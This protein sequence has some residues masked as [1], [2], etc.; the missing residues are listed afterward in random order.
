MGVIIRNT[1]P[2]LDQLQLTDRELMREVG[3]LARERIIRRTAAGK[4]RDGMSFRPYSAGYAKRKREE[5]GGGDVNLQVSGEMLRGLQIV[6]L[7]DR[8]VTLGWVT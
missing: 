5:L 3:L 2:K 1:I 7:T 4:D 6:D 8:K